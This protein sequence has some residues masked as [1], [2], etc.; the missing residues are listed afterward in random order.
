MMV[1]NF[2]FPFLARTI[3]WEILTGMDV[4]NFQECKKKKKTVTQLV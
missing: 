2:V 3:F 1:L 4:K